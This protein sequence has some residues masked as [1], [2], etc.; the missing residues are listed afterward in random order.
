MLADLCVCPFYPKLTL[1]P[2]CYYHK[3]SNWTK[4]DCAL[5]SDESRF[6]LSSDCGRQLIWCKSDAAYREKNIQERGRYTTASIM[7]NRRTRLHVVAIGTMK[8]HLYI[9]EILLPQVC[10]FRGAACDKYVIMDYKATY[11][12]TLAVHDCIY[13]VGIQC[14]VWSDRS[15]LSKPC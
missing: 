11:N 8:D 3:H 10:I 6:S 4:Q 14:L 12:R 2:V 13:S 15:F 9:D 7:I 1:L 5:F